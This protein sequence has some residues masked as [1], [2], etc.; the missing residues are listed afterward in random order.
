[1]AQ[2]YFSGV[3]ID[4]PILVT[5]ENLVALG[6]IID[7]YTQKLGRE[8]EQSLREHIERA[9]SEIPEPPVDASAEEKKDYERRRNAA[10]EREKGFHSDRLKVEQSVAL[11]LPGDRE[12][13]A[14]NLAELLSHAAIES[15]IPTRL[16]IRVTKGLFSSLTF[17]LGNSGLYA[18]IEDQETLGALRG[19]AA[20]LAQS[21]WLR[22]WTKVGSTPG[23][24]MWLV[25]IASSATVLTNGS[26]SL[27][28]EQAYELLRRGLR[29]EDHPKAIAILLA[30][31]SGYSPGTTR[32]VV[33]HWFW[34][35]VCIGGVINIALSFGPPQLI[36][37]IG[38][39]ARTLRRWTAWIAFLKWAVPTV[40]VSGFLIPFL[41]Q[42]L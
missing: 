17:D 30:L 9:E 36:L 7:A 6:K 40:I 37:G 42:L 5:K 8:G 1:M 3:S 20:A 22:T 27:F 21:W 31:E 33:P 25:S 26:R 16:V 18:S 41:R 11:T 38:G 10:V 12:V 4:Q 23:W 2:V 35:L 32:V 28:K 15:D 24:V 14:K 39:G 19:W 13:K 34:W 29:A